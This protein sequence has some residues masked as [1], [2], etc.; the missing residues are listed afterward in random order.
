MSGA[1]AQRERLELY[2]HLGDEIA[3]DELEENLVRHLRRWAPVCRT[4][5]HAGDRTS[6]ATAGGSCR[7]S[8]EVSVVSYLGT[9]GFSDQYLVEL[10]VFLACA[11]E[12]GLHTDP[13]LQ[14]TW[15][16]ISINFFSAPQA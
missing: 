14:A 3:P 15:T 10:P 9:H 8:R 2:A 5:R 12:A 1:P 4:V 7:Q 16:T 13:R 6:Y 11:K